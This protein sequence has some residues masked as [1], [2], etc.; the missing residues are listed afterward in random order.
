ML[1]FE[2]VYLQSYK[3]KVIVEVKSKVYQFLKCIL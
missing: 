1:Q 3:T 2:N